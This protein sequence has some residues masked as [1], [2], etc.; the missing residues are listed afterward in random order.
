MRR[1][2][3]SRRSVYRFLASNLRAFQ[4]LVCHSYLRR[5]ILLR[6]AEQNFFY[7]TQHVVLSSRIFFAPPVDNLA[8]FDDASVSSRHV[9]GA[10]AF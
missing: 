1:G 8:C 6:G 9:E 5:Y 7:G 2:C 4:I 3:S 10:Q